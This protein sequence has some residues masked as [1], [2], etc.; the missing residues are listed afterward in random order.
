MPGVTVTTL[1]LLVFKLYYKFISVFKVLKSQIRIAATPVRILFI[2]LIG[3]NGCVS[4][5][6]E[7]LAGFWGRMGLQSDLDNVYLSQRACL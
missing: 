6:P 3:L 7:D 5:S 4:D 1:L 2:Y